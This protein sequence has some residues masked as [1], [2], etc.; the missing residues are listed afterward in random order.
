MKV[1]KPIKSKVKHVFDKLEKKVVENYELL[2][3]PL[4]HR[5]TDGLY[6]REVSVPK[7]CV[8]TSKI[9]KVQ[10]QFFILKGK[11]LIWDENG[12]EQMVE[13]PYI[14]ITQENTRR[15]VYAMED[16]VWATCHPNPENK[17]LSEIE[18]E[19]FDVDS[20]ELLDNG[21][22]QKIQNAENISKKNSITIDNVKNNILCRQW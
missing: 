21:M 7:G 14:G 2:S 3:L 5:F 20:N 17:I 9:H 10:H 4:T 6:V 12:N 16:F 1:N 15:V 13:A 11:V 18:N 22:L 19:M 8:V